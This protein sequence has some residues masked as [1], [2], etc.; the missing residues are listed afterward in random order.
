MNRAI[1]GSIAKYDEFTFKKSLNEGFTLGAIEAAAQDDISAHAN[2]KAVQNKKIAQMNAEYEESG[3]KLVVPT[4]TADTVWRLEG[5]LDSRLQSF[6]SLEQLHSMSHASYYL[7]GYAAA[8]LFYGSN[9]DELVNNRIRR[10][11][12]YY[13]DARVS[14]LSLAEA[15]KQLPIQN[16]SAESFLTNLKQTLQSCHSRVTILFLAAC[17]DN[18]VRIRSDREQRIIEE[19]LRKSM[20]SEAYKLHDVKSCKVRDITTALRKFKPSILHFSGHASKDGLVFENE[21][22][23]FD[24]IDTERLSLVMKQGAKNGLQTVVLN[25]CSTAEQSDC[26]ANIVG[27]VIAMKDAVNDTASIDFMRVFYGSLAEG[28]EVEDAFKWASSDSELLYRPD[29]IRPLL[30]TGGTKSK[31][32][33]EEAQKKPA[34]KGSNPVLSEGK[35]EVG[36]AQGQGLFDNPNDNRKTTLVETEVDEDESEETDDGGM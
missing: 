23:G 26:I 17:P 31:K 10:I 4:C 13:Q 16:Q 12:L 24:L 33:I 3:L 29:M 14:E 9:P 21:Q 15:I 22:G 28:H 34:K 2:N 7:I 8:G 1:L 11:N 18:A 19:E 32:A 20:F 27:C 6:R 30:I 25:A 36:S 35:V 5:I